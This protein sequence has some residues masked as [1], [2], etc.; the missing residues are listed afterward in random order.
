MP[1]ISS[2]HVVGHAQSD[3]RR[4]VTETHTLNVGA[5]VLIEYLAAVGADY[6]SIRDARV[7]QINTRLAEAEADEACK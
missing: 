5:P 3:G 1:V 2:S 7:E 4:Y 6:V